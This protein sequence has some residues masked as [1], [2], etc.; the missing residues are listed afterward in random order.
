MAVREKLVFFSVQNFE[1]YW[2]YTKRTGP[3]NCTIEGLDLLHFQHHCKTVQTHLFVISFTR[4]TQLMCFTLLYSANRTS[5][6]A[7]QTDTG[8][9]Y[10]IAE[11]HLFYINRKNET[12]HFNSVL[13]FTQSPAP[14]DP[15]T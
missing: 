14:Q 6:H 15:S 12:S 7:F 13:T 10:Y 5:W 8:A 1:I 4:R 2:L 3:V 9:L 11:N